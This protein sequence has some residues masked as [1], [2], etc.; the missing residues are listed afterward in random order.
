MRKKSSVKKK[1]TKADLLRE[2]KLDPKLTLRYTG[3]AGIYW[4]YLSRQVRQE[5]FKKYGGKCV[6]CDAVMERWQDGD[7]GHFIS[8]GSGGFAT[9][10]MR[11]NLALQCRRCNNPS[12]SP[13]A[14]AFYARE[15]DRRWGVGTAEML[16]NLK[17]VKQKEMKKEQYADAI[18]ALP[19]FNGV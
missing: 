13:D 18:R 17:G 12:W 14:S 16:M 6:S 10:F 15:I 2:W 19:S 1:Q 5:D 8:S 9:R 4:I 7:C 3:I 11:Q